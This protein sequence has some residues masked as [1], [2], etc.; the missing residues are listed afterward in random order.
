MGQ[1]IMRCHDTHGDEWT[2]R[3]ETCRR[4]TH[5]YRYTVY[6]NGRFAYTAYSRREMAQYISG[7]TA[8]TKAPAYM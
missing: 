6:R 8:V 3:V 7:A 4:G 1:L 5:P 2:G